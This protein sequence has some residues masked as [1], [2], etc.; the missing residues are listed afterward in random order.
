[1]ADVKL[2]KLVLK[3]EKG[4]SVTAL[5]NPKEM[6]IDKSVPWQQQKD[7]KGDAPPVE[8]TTGAPKS[9]SFELLFDLFEDK[10]DVHDT[11]I[12]KLEKMVMIDPG[13]KRPPMVTVAWSNKFP[14][15]KGVVESM[16]V[17]YTMF[18]NTGSPCRCTVTMKV[19]EAQSAQVK[20]SK[21]KK[22]DHRK[23][24]DASGN[25]PSPGTPG[26]TPGGGS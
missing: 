4:D 6:G 20:E 25:P 9:M 14:A 17:K 22:S 18:L 5:F 8:F 26:T 10:G 21:K 19:K 11:Y 15:F 7:A 24:A 16:N 12:S 2:E 13:L 23:D 1:M 3:S